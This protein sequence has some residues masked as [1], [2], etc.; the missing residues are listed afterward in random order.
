M[1]M[2][3]GKFIEQG[4]KLGTLYPESAFATNDLIEDFYNM[5]MESAIRKSG[6]TPTYGDNGYFNA[7]F[8]MEITAGFFLCD[9]IFTALGT[10]PYNHEGVRITADPSDASVYDAAGNFLGVGAFTVQDGNLPAPVSLP[11]D[12][13]RMPYKELPQL[14]NYGMGLKLLANKKDDTV[15]YNDYV[16]KIVKMYAHNMDQTILRPIWSPQ[17][18]V[19]GVETSLNS[20]ARI[21]SG[22]NEIGT[23]QNGITITDR[24]VSAYGGRGDSLGDLYKFRS[25]GESNYDG[26][27]IDAKGGALGISDLNNLWT[28]CSVNWNS[29]GNSNGKFWAMGNI[30]QAKVSALQAASQMLTNAVFVQRSFN[31]VKTVEGR[32][33]GLLLNSYMHI[34]ILVDGNINYNYKKGAV[35]KVRMGDIYLED[36]DHKWFS[37]LSPVENWS[38]DNPLLTGALREKNMLHMRGELRADYFISSGRIINLQD[39][40][41]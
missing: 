15:A 10:K 23:V 34:P 11:V 28:Q 16:S 22:F 4:G 5:H 18:T 13:I 6:G 33:G 2:I 19:D 14:Y 39:A 36:S 12:E 26:Q 29:G 40:T 35:S 38:V 9:N 1:D 24:D 8:G 31:G 20:I 37:L 17:P 21:D 27:L 41:A 3:G 25:K 7:V 32:E 30:A